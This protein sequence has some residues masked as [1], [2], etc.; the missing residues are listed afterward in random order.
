MK[1]D[2]KTQLSIVIPNQPG[3][4]AKVT[5]A[6][7]K[8]KINIGSL[9]FVDTTSQ[10]VVRFVVDDAKEAKKL[11]EN[12]GFFVAAAEVAVV[13]VPNKVGALYHISKA[14]GDAGINIEY[15][16]ASD[17]PNVDCTRDTFK[18]SDVARG[19]EIIEKL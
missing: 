6:M 5:G 11:L 2:I 1:V 12:K 7:M 17:N 18:L 3:Q 19:V 8:H 4:I 10:G 16:Y 9:M 13:E 15:A 14:L